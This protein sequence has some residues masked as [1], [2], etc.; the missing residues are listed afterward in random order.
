MPESS[1]DLCREI[2]A[3]GVPDDVALCLCIFSI[4]IAI[5]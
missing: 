4:E 5:D 3:C 1:D 2:Q